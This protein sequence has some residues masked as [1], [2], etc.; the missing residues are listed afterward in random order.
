MKG[1]EGTEAG[2]RGT[3][4]E[5]GLAG[6]AAFAAGAGDGG[7]WSGGGDAVEGARGV[8]EHPARLGATVP[9]RR[10]GRQL[11]QAPQRGSP[12][13]FVVDAP[14]D[15]TF[16]DLSPPALSRDGRYLAFAA[17]SA[18]GGGQ[19]KWRRDGK[20]LFYLA[21]DGGLM[22]AAVRDGTKGLE[23]GLPHKF[24]Q[25]ASLRAVV[26]RLAY[27]DYAV[28]ADS[29]RFLC[30]SS[31]VAASGAASTCCSTG[32]RSSPERAPRRPETGPL[33]QGLSV[34]RGSGIRR[35]NACTQMIHEGATRSSRL[36]PGPE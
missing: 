20:E 16:P 18:N 14:D 13:H 22:A 6:G 25:A 36:W 5:T 29:Q 31:R 7:P 2:R 8:A 15:L 35:A 1:R 4:S 34:G 23:V 28:P 19:P 11:R 33:H 9:A 12:V 26:Q 24:I 30:K 17:V 32:R 27:S 3:P 10:S 21:P